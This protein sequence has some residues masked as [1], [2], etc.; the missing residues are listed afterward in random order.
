MTSKPSDEKEKWQLIALDVTRDAEDFARSLLF[1]LGTTGIVTHEERDKTVTLGAYFD[2]QADTEQTAA[3]IRSE[4]ARLERTD[5]LRGVS[6]STVPEQ[7]WMQKWKEG[8][9]PVEIG[10]RFIVAPSWKLPVDVDG[11]IVVQIDPGMA[12][13]TG[14]H[15]TTRM[16][17]EAVESHWRGG[18]LLDVGTGTAILAIAAALLVPGPRIK[19]IDIDPQ[20]VEVARENTAINR[21]Q[22]S[23]DVI[24]GGPRE[25]VGRAFDVVV[26]NLTAEVII[27]LIDDLA[28][29]LASAGTMIL[30]GILT[31]LEADVESAATRAGMTTIERR[32]LGEWSALVI[33]KR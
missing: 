16:C 4:F 27:S 14:T 13:G 22:E 11:R 10:N 12:F 24:E 20:A 5:E 6:V 3:A 30:S 8:F 19:A 26:A 15:E 17:L 2:P 31:T 33:R 18:S 23:I 25:F 21:V 1:E 9:E 28:A 7:D 29:C 32:R